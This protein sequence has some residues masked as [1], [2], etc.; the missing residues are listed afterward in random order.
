MC[1]LKLGI[2][3]FVYVDEVVSEGL[4]KLEITLTSN[5]RPCDFKD[6]TLHTYSD[7]FLLRIVSCK[8]ILESSSCP[9]FKKIV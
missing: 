6:V 4:D 3:D 8:H 2:I 7:A 9:L 5:C 1:N